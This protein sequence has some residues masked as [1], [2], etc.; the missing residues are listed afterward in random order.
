M[1]MHRKSHLRKMEIIFFVQVLFAL[2]LLTSCA[3]ENDGYMFGESAFPVFDSHQ[4][5]DY[6]P[7][8]VRVNIY[9]Q[10]TENMANLLS[11]PYY[12]YA[13]RTLKDTAADIWTTHGISQHLFRFDF[14]WQNE[15][16]REEGYVLTPHHFAYPLD[17]EWWVRLDINPPQIP[18]IFE[19]HFYNLRW[20]TEQ[21]SRAPDSYLGFYHG[22]RSFTVSQQSHISRTIREISELR[23]GDNEIS[24]MVTNFIG[25]PQE[26]I[27]IRDSI[28]YFLHENPLSAISTFTFDG[29]F[30]LVF[31]STGEVVEF[32]N[33]LS[34]RL[35]N[36]NSIPHVFS[37]H[38][39]AA[40]VSSAFG[41]EYVQVRETY[42][43]VREIFSEDISSDEL[44]LFERRMGNDWIF[45]NVFSQLIS[46]N[47][48]PIS[49][50]IDIPTHAL[51]S[52]MINLEVNVSL[53][54]YNQGARRNIPL[55]N[56]RATIENITG[57]KAAN[58]YTFID[59]TAFTELSTNRGLL[60]IHIYERLNTNRNEVHLSPAVSVDGIVPNMSN[61]VA[62]E[63][64][65]EIFNRLNSDIGNVATQHR[66]GEI[67]LHFI[68]R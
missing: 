26:T 52:D 58:V 32:S 21:Y 38:T 29:F 24:I 28:L 65:R 61:S 34:Y 12:E 51:V 40:I 10:G 64:F 22:I 35:I 11:N 1:E 17:P 56:T 18:Q 2:V 36:A 9:V 33:R 13:V 30:F 27:A 45:F 55:R 63:E 3:N 14:E 5:N 31:G 48:A 25:H 37:I 41:N 44:A 39:Y 53:Y 16:R 47:I 57:E 42:R 66:I 20:Y 8:I 4:D 60:V 62:L 68:Y 43:G 23:S 15:A 59:T 49:L 50:S 67:Y 46:D 6:E 54:D 19:E 7:Y